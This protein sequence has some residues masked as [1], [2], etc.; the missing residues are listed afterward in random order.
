VGSD[1]SGNLIEA[2]KD[3]TAKSGLKNIEY[4]QADGQGSDAHHG[5]YDLVL[6]H[7]VISHV[8]NPAALLREAI[9][10]ARPGGQIILHECDYASMT[11]NTNTPELDLKM[12]EL[13]LQAAFGKHHLLL[14]LLHVL[15]NS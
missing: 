10:L 11:F 12:T 15:L 9:R 2:A 5:Q 14:Y 6:V 13:I 8:A 7:T 1:L 4:Y 3:I